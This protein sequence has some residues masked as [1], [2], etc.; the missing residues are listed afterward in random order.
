MRS[1][2]PLTDA[3]PQTK[4]LE[5]EHARLTL[6][7][8]APLGDCY[9]QFEGE[10][11][12]VFGGIPGE[13]VLA[14]IVRYRRRRRKFIS[15]IVTRVLTPSPHRVAPPCP[16]FGPCTGCQWQHVSYAHQLRLKRAAVVIEMTHYAELEGIPVSSTIPSPQ[17]FNYRNHA[18][19]TV[20]EGGS[21]GFTNR[22]T[23]RFAR[24]NEC[25]LM[26]PGIND[27][28][29]ELQSK[30]AE[31]TQLSVRFGINTGDVLIQPT[32]QN[33]DIG[34]PSGQTHYVERLLGHY[35][36]VAS[37][38]FFQVNTA[39]A[40]RMAQ[41]VRDRLQLGK[42]DTL[43]DAYAGVGSFAILLA[44]YVR[45][46][47]AVEES[48]AAIRDAIHN[49]EGVDN[50]EFIE[51]KTEDA[52]DELDASVDAVILDPPR[53]GC[54]PKALRALIRRPPRRVVYVSCEP[55]TL[56]RDLSVLVGGGFRVESIEPV[57]MFPQTHHVEVVAA[58]SSGQMACHGQEV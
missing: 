18:R 1:T 56:A 13:E 21:L 42:D 17:A 55:E 28:L 12:N 31:T 5:D 25:M 23:R 3:S 34:F 9:A 57:D 46:V 15:A 30:C 39:Q 20:R 2:W 10:A 27:T 16:Y 33:P 32:L 19:F 49:A 38:S 11:I 45:R 50:L 41:L 7:G 48:A 29:R 53:A 58:L 4:P 52:L 26:A 47:I 54:D 36:R 40:E 44:P 8:M 43:L 6:D 24:V 35:F 37:P 14:R 22:I 51:A